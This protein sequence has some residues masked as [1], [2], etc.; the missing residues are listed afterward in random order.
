MIYK[1]RHCLVCF[2]IF[3]PSTSREAWC[4]NDC[5]F[6]SHINPDWSEHQCWEW[7]GALF[8]TTGYGQFGSV[9][10]GVFTAHKYS[11]QLFK[12]QVPEG[13]YVCHSCDNRKCFNPNHL[14]IGTP[15]E[16]SQDM[17]K[18]GRFNY[19]RN[20]PKGENHWQKKRIAAKKLQKE[21]SND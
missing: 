17:M 7:N 13:L 12:G 10:S 8:K 18:K 19:N 5:R 6:K 20:L 15:K 9:K 16:N 3:Q 11:Y 1:P 2:A 21:L 14:W 4:S